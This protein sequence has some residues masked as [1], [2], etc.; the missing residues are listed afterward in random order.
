[1]SVFLQ[2]KIPPDQQVWHFRGRPLEDGQTLFDVG[3]H[4]DDIITIK[5]RPLPVDDVEEDKLDEATCLE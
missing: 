4:K 1:M 2:V 5:A 3:V